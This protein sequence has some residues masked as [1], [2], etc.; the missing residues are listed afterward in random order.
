MLL[1]LNSKLIFESELNLSPI[2]TWGTFWFSGKSS[3]GGGGKVVGTS[4]SSVGGTTQRRDRLENE[5]QTKL[6]FVETQW[7]INGECCRILIRHNKY[8]GIINSQKTSL[9]FVLKKLRMQSESLFNIFLIWLKTFYVT[10]K[11]SYLK[12]MI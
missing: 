12:I 7:N 6:F 3:S 10:I 2:F 8:G 4:Q 11:I 1:E 9:V 5:N